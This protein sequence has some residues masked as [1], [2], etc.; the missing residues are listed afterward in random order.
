MFR[1]S[2]VFAWLFILILF[3]LVGCSDNPTSPAPSTENPVLGESASSS[4]HQCLGFHMVEIDTESYSVEIIPL[5]STEWHF[6]LTG[7]LNSTMGVSAAGVPSEHDPANGLFVFDITLAHPFDTS[8]QL[9][10][11]DVKGILITPGTYAVGSLVYAGAD[12]TRLENADGYTRWWNPTEFTSP[13]MLGYEDGILASAPASALTATINPYKLFADILY[14]T[15]NLGSVCYEPLD[16]DQGRAVFTA[17][18]SNTR[19]YEIRFP[20]DPGPLVVYG[21]AIDCAWNPPSPNPP[22]E[23]PDDFPMNANQP[24]AYRIG[25]KTVANTLYYDDEFGVGGGVLRLE[26]GVFDWQGQ[27]AGNIPPEIDAV[28]I[29]APDLMPSG[30]DGILQYKT[31]EKAVY[32]ADLTGVAEP[33]EAGETLVICRVASSDGSTYQQTGAPAPTDSL[34]AYQVLALDIPDPDCAADANNDFGEAV[35]IDFGG[36]AIDQVCNPD[37]GYDFYSFYIPVGYEA[38]GEIRLN[39]N[40]DPPWPTQPTLRLYDGSESHIADVYVADG[41]AVLS[42]DELALMPGQY[43]IRVGSPCCDNVV[44]YLLEL[45][46]ELVDVV[47]IDPVDVTPETLY[48]NPRYVWLHDQYA[49]LC[50][51][52]CWVYDL[53]DPANPIQVANEDYYLA[54]VGNFHYPYCYYSTISGI[55]ERQLG[56]V[57][58]TDPLA[59]V[60][61]EG[62]ITYPD[63]IKGICLDSTHLYLHTGSAPAYEIKIY[64][65]ITDPL[66]PV[67]VGSIPITYYTYYMALTEIDGF[68]KYL[69][70]G[71]ADGAMIHAYSVDDPSAVTDVVPYPF[72]AGSPRGMSTR[73]NL[74]YLAYAKSGNDGWLYVMHLDPSMPGFFE[75]GSVDIPGEGGFTALDWPYVFIGDTSAGLTVCDVS[76][77]STPIHKCSVP[78]ISLGGHLSIN[79]HILC[80]APYNAGLQVFDIQNPSLPDPI[81]RLKVV[82][83]PW[84][85]VVS[86]DYLIVADMAFGYSAIKTVDISD[87]SNAHVVG[88]FFLSVPPCYLDL[89]NDILAVASMKQ[90]MLFDASDPTDLS[91]IIAVPLPEDIMAIAM[92]NDA[93]YVALDS[94]KVVTYDIGS[95]PFVTTTDMFVAPDIARGFSFYWACM[96]LDTDPG[97]EIYSVADPLNPSYI[98]AYPMASD[99]EDSSVQGDY[100]YLITDTDLEIANLSDPS[101][102]AF[103]STIDVGA[104]DPLDGITMVGQFAYIHGSKPMPPYFCNVWP[105]DSPSALGQVHPGEYTISSMVIDNSYLYE[106]VPYYKGI[107]IFQLY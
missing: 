80:I 82:N 45:D 106:M 70:V 75:F 19:R 83:N 77:P 30:V 2:L 1:S 89:Q 33:S 95:L 16:S 17:G 107:H 21:Y 100:I 87:P 13:G 24:E 55:D 56:L 104:F 41:V 85:A 23:V 46:G 47:P 84:S 15:S 10:G 5:R 88:E 94:K 79:E 11:F 92:H 25:I 90:W 42:F 43:Y 60:Q 98:G 37:D 27:A 103:E 57:D 81:A 39:A 28:R 54:E 86:G 96:Y 59:P 49:F 50:G 51:Y 58:F 61:H 53:T 73:G 71:D 74:I 68:G 35:P 72:P 64:D 4:S 9:A 63:G 67:E 32:M 22:G 99:L 8:P 48:V 52:E 65:Y 102:P 3:I 105:S 12:E 31:A 93:L 66:D 26:I 62:L 14:P 91:L 78:L 29:I 7:V 101:I 18:S 6:N 40:A 20:M 97:L 34:S 36:E 44:P 76:I 69:V 38:T